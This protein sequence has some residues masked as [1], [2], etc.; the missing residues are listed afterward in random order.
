MLIRNT[1][2]VSKPQQQ[3]SCCV[4]VHDA[5]IL[6]FS[7]L[8]DINPHS[9]AIIPDTKAISSSIMELFLCYLCLLI[10]TP[11]ASFI[12][13]SSFMLPFKPLLSVFLTIFCTFTDLS[14]CLH[15]LFPLNHPLCVLP[16]SYSF[17]HFIPPE[18][19]A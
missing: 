6:L 10:I 11:Y 12:L 4:F 1:A 9:V 2:S 19:V 14:I 3:R 18:Q 17:P 5:S 13:L 8:W 7:T 16:M 15:F